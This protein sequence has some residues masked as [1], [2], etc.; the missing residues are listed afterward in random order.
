MSVP[1][2]KVGRNSQLR[3][4]ISLHFFRAIATSCVLY[5]WTLE[6]SQGYSIIWRGCVEICCS[7]YWF[8]ESVW[9]KNLLRAHSTTQ[10][11]VTQ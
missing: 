3:H 1:T 10:F 8:Q 2:Q 6:D 7:S 11:S 9:Q 5:T 4:V